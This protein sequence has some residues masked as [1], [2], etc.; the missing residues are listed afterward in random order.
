MP[1]MNV[2][3]SLPKPLILWADT[4]WLEPGR[5]AV[6]L[7][8][9]KVALEIVEAKEDWKEGNSR[10][11]F[12]VSLHGSTR[13]Q[14]TEFEQRGISY[15]DS[16]GYLHL[17][18]D[19]F[20]VH[21]ERGTKSQKDLRAL[22][23]AL[24]HGLPLSLGAAAL[25]VG[26]GCLISDDLSVTRLSKAV[27]VS[28]GQTH[29]TLRSLEE[30]GLVR[31]LGRGPAMK[32]QLIDRTKL[33]NLLRQSVLAQRPPRA[34]I[35]YVYARTPTALWD[36]LAEIKEHAVVSGSAAAYL[37]GGVGATQV[38]RTLVRVA[39]D[40]LETVARRLEAQPA[41][42]GA[43]VA[44]VPDKALLR[45]ISPALAGRVPVANNVVVWLD[46]LHEPRGEE[47]AAQ[48]R[49]TKLGY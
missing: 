23:N 49:E 33:A 45:V 43:N 18:G 10:H 4:P 8:K 9:R 26:I 25:R 14:R 7:A 21:L 16:E 28:V 24:V 42:S 30:A 38:P 29:E 46:C 44:L 36:R 1:K 12:V 27:A 2:R 17:V 39:P 3:V 31:R 41:E 40:A 19:A 20:F 35:V 32:R 15:V 47:I 37:V 6:E 13:A 5:G 11:A 34:T 48:F 22:R